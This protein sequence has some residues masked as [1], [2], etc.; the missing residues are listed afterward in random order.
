MG[1]ELRRVDLDN[2]PRRGVQWEGFINPFENEVQQC[3]HC[4]HGYSPAAEK[5]VAQWYGHESFDPAEYGATPIQVDDPEFVRVIRD[6]VHFSIERAKAEGRRCYY[7][8]G[9][10]HSQEA[11]TEIEARRMYEIIKN[12]WSHHL[13]QEDVDALIAEGRLLDLTSTW[14]RDERR[15]V[16][17]PGKV[18]TVE[19]VNIWSLSGFGHDSMNCHVCVKA[20]CERKGLPHT[21]SACDGS[22]EYWPSQELKA[23]YEAWQPSPPPEGDGYQL[24][25]TVSTGSPVSPAFATKGELASWLAKYDTSATTGGTSEQ[26]WMKFFDVGWAPTA[27]IQNGEYMSGVAAMANLKAE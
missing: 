23:K 10:K 9:G 15:W 8:E 18:V 3:A 16:P 2:P 26:G 13:R 4:A 17:I 7:T 14:D 6:K 20:R 12:M 24:W 27:V 1:R 22:G 25:E 21:C 11:A 5:F 19:E